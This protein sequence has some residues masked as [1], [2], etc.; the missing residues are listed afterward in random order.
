V[1]IVLTK[2][3]CAGDKKDLQEIYGLPNGKSREHFE[4]HDLDLSGKEFKAE[5]SVS[6]PFRTQKHEWGSAAWFQSAKV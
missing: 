5:V 2:L 6:G 3:N 4:L 1:P